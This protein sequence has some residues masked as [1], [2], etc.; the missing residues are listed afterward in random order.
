MQGCSPAN[1]FLRAF[2][3]ILIEIYGNFTVVGDVVGAV[4]GVVLGAL[5]GNVV[6]SVDGEVVG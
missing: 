3:P 1:P 4:V 6:G 2:G 5:E